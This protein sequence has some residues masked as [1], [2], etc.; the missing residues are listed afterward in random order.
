MFCFMVKAVRG[1]GYDVLRQAYD[2]GIVSG[3]TEISVSLNAR[4]FFDK[5]REG[6][7]KL[8]SHCGRSIRLQK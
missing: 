7:Y 6:V 2:G 3:G 8:G 1:K 5:L 4:G